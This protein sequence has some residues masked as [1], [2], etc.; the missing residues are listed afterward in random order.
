MRMRF[1]I[2]AGAM[3]ALGLTSLPAALPASALEVGQKAPDFTVVAP[4]NKQIKLSDML[5]KGPVVIY[6]FIQAFTPT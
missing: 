3:L 5:G 1:M 4:G 6:T 2:L